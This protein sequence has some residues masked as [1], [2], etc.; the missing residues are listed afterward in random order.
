MFYYIRGKLVA[1]EPTYAVIDAAGVGYKLTISIMTRESLPAFR[2]AKEAPEVLLYTHFAVRED[3]VELFGFIDEE[4]LRTF[5]ILTSISGV[6]P[7]AAMS[8][9]STLTPA[10]LAIAVSSEDKRAIASANGI[11]AKTAARII[12]ELKDKL[13][14]IPTGE[15]GEAYVSDIKDSKSVP[16]NS[17]SEASEALS[18]LGYSKPEILNALKGVNPDQPTDAIIKEAL[19]KLF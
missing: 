18:A 16:K 7:K 12:L 1:A 9:L 3:G 17:L 6:G 19:K 10:K 14:F 4:E 11:G 8:I 15:I 2:S 5:R 13:S